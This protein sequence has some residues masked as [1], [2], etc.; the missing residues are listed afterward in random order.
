MKYYYND[1]AKERMDMLS[2]ENG[3]TYNISLYDASSGMQSLVPMTVLM[4]YLVTD[5][6]K[7]YG[8]TSLLL[9]GKNIKA[10]W[11]YRRV[12]YDEE[13]RMPQDGFCSYGERKED[14]EG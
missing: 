2:H 3:V 14:K 12:R 10:G 11:C 7:N 13:Y 4:H 9:D 1:K 8:K 6:F 5:Y